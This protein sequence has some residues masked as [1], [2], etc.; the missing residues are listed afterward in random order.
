MDTESPPVHASICEDSK[1]AGPGPTL[2]CSSEQSHGASLGQENIMHS[3]Q[4]LIWPN[5][6]SKQGT[7]QTAREGT[8]NTLA[9]SG[10]GMGDPTNAYIFLIDIPASPQAHTP[11][12]TISPGPGSTTTITAVSTRRARG[13]TPTPDSRSG[14]AGWRKETGP[15]ACRMAAGLS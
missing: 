10:D 3:S 14:E 15:G 13:P 6:D 9:F 12:W 2:G 8:A 7:E 1:Q 11:G 5:S 4:E